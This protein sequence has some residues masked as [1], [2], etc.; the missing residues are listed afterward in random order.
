MIHDCFRFLQDP[1]K[2]CIG[3]GVCKGFGFVG[4]EFNGS[5]FRGSGLG[6]LG[7]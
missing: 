6:G 3:G 7:F 4:V 1:C 2:S 5:G